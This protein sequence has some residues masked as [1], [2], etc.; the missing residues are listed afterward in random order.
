MDMDG[1]NQ[2]SAGADQDERYTRAAAAFAGALERLSRAYEADPAER[3]DLL[4]DIHFALWRSFAR[5]DGLC[6]E[7]TWIYR[8]AHNAAT[9]H[10]L[11]RVRRK[12]QTFVT[13]D[14]LGAYGD[15]AQPDP[16]A[17]T[18]DRQALNRLTSLIRMLAP[19]DRQVVLLY[20]EGLPAADIGDICGLSPGAVAT[21]LHRLRAALT[22]QFN[23]GGIHVR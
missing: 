23:K 20:L 19:P 2:T 16:E 5:F 1:A 3:D 18:A 13:L 10:V 15:P 6:S 4:Q 21:K 17:E 22:Q 14:E 11:K 9:S 7:A 8:V 12:R